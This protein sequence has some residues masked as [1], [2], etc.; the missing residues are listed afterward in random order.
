MDNAKSQVGKKVGASILLQTK[1]MCITRLTCKVLHLCQKEVER[2]FNYKNFYAI[3]VDE[4]CLIDKKPLI[5]EMLAEYCDKCLKKN[6][7]NGKKKE[8]F[9]VDSHVKN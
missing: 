6:K 1:L 3:I 9:E 7:T 5:Q 2:S 4:I 8:E